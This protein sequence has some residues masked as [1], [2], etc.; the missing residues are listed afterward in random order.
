MR[1]IRRIPILFVV[2]VLPFFLTSCEEDSP[3][4]AVTRSVHD[5]LVLNGYAESGDLEQ[6]MKNLG[7]VED[8]LCA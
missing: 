7:T 2:A 5:E 3:Q 8:I 1:S 4:E 6:F